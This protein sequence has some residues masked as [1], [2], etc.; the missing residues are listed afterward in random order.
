MQA[1]EVESNKGTTVSLNPLQASKNSNVSDVKMD[2]KHADQSKEVSSALTPQDSDQQPTVPSSSV[3]KETSVK[4][5][6]NVQPGGEAK[7]ESARS[8]GQDGAETLKDPP[9]TEAPAV[10][11]ANPST[12]TDDVANELKQLEEE[13]RFGLDRYCFNGAGSFSLH[14][15]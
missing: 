6:S 12:V 9:I 3:L 14:V 11:T 10:H 15:H 2:E 8:R 13:K 4:A 7:S 5:V 1:I